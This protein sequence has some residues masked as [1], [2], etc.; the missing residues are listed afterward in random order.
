MA[1]GFEYTL[2]VDEQSSLTELNK[3]IQSIS[4]FE[5]SLSLDLDYN[6]CMEAI[7]KL[8]S[9]I[10]TLDT[11]MSIQIN[12]FEIDETDLQAELYRKSRDLKLLL[13]VEFD[14]MALAQSMQEVD[15]PTEKIKE[16][17]ERDVVLIQDSVKK[18]LNNLNAQM[19][20]A[21]I[22]ADIIDVD[23]IERSINELS[24][25]T[26]KFDEIKFRAKE[27]KN[28]ISGWQQAIR[29]QN[30]L[31]VETSTQAKQV[32]DAM[33]KANDAFKDDGGGIYADLYRLQFKN[34]Q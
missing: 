30:N 27:I 28:E 7:N 20:K 18:M 31:L 26:M 9:E 12:T 21:N 15:S 17:A 24:L 23:A 29:L 1:I 4:D 19:Q 13:K 14:D 6:N 25:S 5:V 3:F 16:K 32:R 33:A 11:K 22:G 34:N 2:S 8:Q 10:R